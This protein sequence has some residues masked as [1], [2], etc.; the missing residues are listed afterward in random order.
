[1]NVILS[2]QETV[3]GDSSARKGATRFRL[4]GRDAIHSQRAQ[5]IQPVDHIRARYFCSILRQP[6]ITRA[7]FVIQVAHYASI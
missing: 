1:V 7:I 2:D 5:V 4:D 3:M 6:V